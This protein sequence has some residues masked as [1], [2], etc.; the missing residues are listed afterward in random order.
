MMANPHAEQPTLRDRKISCQ[1]RSL[2]G[3]GHQLLIIQLIG[4]ALE[5]SQSKTQFPVPAAK[6]TQKC[7]RVFPLQFDN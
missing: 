3:E 5:E 4:A 6:N 1:V 2:A 7:R